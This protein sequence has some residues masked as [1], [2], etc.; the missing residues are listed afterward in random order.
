[1]KNLWNSVIWTLTSFIILTTNIYCVSLTL[2]TFSRSSATYKMPNFSRHHHYYNLT[3]LKF[4][5]IK[6]YQIQWA[7]SKKLEIQKKI[8]LLSVIAIVTLNFD[9]QNKDIE[10]FKNLSTRR[11]SSERW[12]TAMLIWKLKLTHTL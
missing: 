4:K 10:A 12:L 6:T 1:M 5:K 2:F 3:Y 9:I 11:Y 8:I 7:R